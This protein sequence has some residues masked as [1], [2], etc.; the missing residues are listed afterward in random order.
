MSLKITFRRLELPTRPL[1]EKEYDVVVIG[2]GP[3]G[4]A[5]AIY[6]ARYMLDA[7]LVTKEKGGQLNKI[8]YVENY[9]GILKIM[10]PE[11]IDRL[12]EHLAKYKVPVVL[13]EVIDVK[14]EENKFNVITASDRVFKTKTVILALGVVKRKLGVPGEEEF[15]G[16]GVSYCAPCDAPLFKDKVVAVVGGGDSAVSA[17]LLLAEYARKVY[18]IHRRSRFRAQPYYIRQ[19]ELN[20]KIEF[21]FNS[22]V[23]E[24]GGTKTV[25]WVK[26]KETG[27][28]IFVNGV[29]IEIGAN[30]PA[31]FFRKIGVETDGKGYVKVSKDQSTNIPG[32][33]AAGDCTNAAGAFKQIVVAAAQGAIAADSAY[34]Y[35][36]KEFR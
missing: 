33:F 15:L 29:F 7:I 35:I 10:G 17:S 34:R 28:K 9:P 5:A 24:I 26:I 14:C 31:E 21:I 25:E 8:G 3:A 19:M 16:R 18:V 11:L 27:R 20:P 2:G 23:A 36:I 1:E 12:Y 13:D 22:N 4:V 30:P 32:I 6:A